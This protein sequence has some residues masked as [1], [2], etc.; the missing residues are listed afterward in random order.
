MSTKRGKGGPWTIQSLGSQPSLLG[1]SDIQVAIFEGGRFMAVDKLKLATRATSAPEL[2]ACAAIRFPSG[3]IFAGHRHSDCLSMIN[4][5][6]GNRL[7]HPKD[8]WTQGFMTTRGRFASRREAFL[9]MIDNDIPSACP[10]GYR[11][12]LMELFSEDLY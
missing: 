7:M 4:Y 6:F 8:T 3:T 10:S 9:M 1:D 11:T 12:R 2:P 5:E